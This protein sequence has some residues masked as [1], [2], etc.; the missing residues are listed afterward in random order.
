VLSTPSGRECPC[1]EVY[2]RDH[3]EAPSLGVLVIHSSVLGFQV[4]HL[5]I[6][7]ALGIVSGDGESALE[8]GGP[9][10]CRNH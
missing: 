3:N 6:Q 9:S 7:L 5:Q 10:T 4:V 2:V 1:S 8:P